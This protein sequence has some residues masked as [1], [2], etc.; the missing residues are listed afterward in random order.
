MDLLFI[1]SAGAQDVEDSSAPLLRGL[2]REL[3]DAA[4]ILAPLMPDPDAPDATAWDQAVGRHVAALP[5]PFVAIG[6]SLGGST[7]LRH[8]ALHG[9]PRHLAGLICIAAPFWGTADW[10]VPDYALPPDFAVRLAGLQRLVFF[11]S[12]DDEVADVVHL[13]RY[14]AEL[15]WVELREVSGCGHIFAD[16]PVGVIAEDARSMLKAAAPGSGK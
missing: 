15:P 5:R 7:L 1:H 3:G 9:V 16:G 14:G 6:H 10:E 4:N 11:H 13:R 12:S 8:L 2:R